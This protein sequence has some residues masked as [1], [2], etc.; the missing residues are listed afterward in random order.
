ME[1]H[2]VIRDVVFYDKKSKKPLLSW[3]ENDCQCD[4]NISDSDVV[5]VRTEIQNPFTFDSSVKREYIFSAF[6][7]ECSNIMLQKLGEAYALEKPF[8][9]KMQGDMWVQARKHKKKR[10]NK[11]WR[12]R[13]GMKKVKYTY[14]HLYYVRPS[15]V[16][17]KV[18]L[19]FYN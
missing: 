1:E 9:I 15:Q 18:K 14:S 17:G 7:K 13:Y 6:A 16:E 8:N 10:I 12:K 2:K 19:D 5:K 3:S 4:F 11:K